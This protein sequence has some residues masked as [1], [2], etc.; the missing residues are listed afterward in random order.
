MNA[1]MHAVVVIIGRLQPLLMRACVRACLC[2]CVCV[3]LECVFVSNS[4]SR[5][6]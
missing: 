6:F 5:I 1:C 4:D 2:V 3:Y